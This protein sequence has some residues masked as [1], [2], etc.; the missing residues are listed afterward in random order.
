MLNIHFN[1]MGFS[2]GISDCRLY[3]EGLLPRSFEF[4]I[5]KL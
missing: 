5:N 2:K 4:I 1:G 3:G